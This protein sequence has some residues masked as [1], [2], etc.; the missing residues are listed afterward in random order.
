MAGL[1]PRLSV[2]RNSLKRILSP[3]LTT[4]QVHHV[5]IRSSADVPPSVIVCPTGMAYY[6]WSGISVLARSCREVGCLVGSTPGP[7]SPS[8]TKGAPQY[9][10][11]LMG[12]SKPSAVKTL[13]ECLPRLKAGRAR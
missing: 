12:A 13:A 6:G 7:T 11:V 3:H 10:A 5:D 2:A 1:N 4:W 9:N 8:G